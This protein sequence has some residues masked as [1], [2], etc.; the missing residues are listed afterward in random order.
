MEE[1]LDT[2]QPEKLTKDQKYYRHKKLKEKEREEKLFLY[3]FLIW[4]LFATII[5]L[6]FHIWKR[7]RGGKIEKKEEK[8]TFQLSYIPI[9]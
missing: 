6:L 3:S 9:R 1:T 7:E 2:T 4:V 5:G 8:P